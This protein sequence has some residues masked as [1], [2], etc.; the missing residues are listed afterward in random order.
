VAM[1]ADL[2][3]DTPRRLST[4]TLA[5]IAALLALALSPLLASLL[6][7]ALVDY[8]KSAIIGLAAFTGSWLSWLAR[9]AA[10]GPLRIAD[11]TRGI[12]NGVEA[13]INLLNTVFADGI[14]TGRGDQV[15][16]LVPPV[17]WLAAIGLAGILAHLIGGRAAG[18][19]LAAL[20]VAGFAYIVVFGF[21]R[22]AMLT[23]SSVIISTIAAVALGIWIGTKAVGRPRLATFVEGLMNVMQ[24]V[25]VFSYLVPTLLF[26]GYGPS[27]ALVATV[28]Y[29]LPPIV[30]ATM[31]GLR[32][33]PAEVIEFG[34]MAGAGQRAM[35]WKIKLPVALPQLA[36]GI[37][38]TIMAC[39]NIV[40]IASM[41]GAGGLGFLVL[42]ALRKL[43]IGGA[44]QAGIAIVVL[45]VILDRLSLAAARLAASGTRIRNSG[46]PYGRMA[47]IWFVAATAAAL[48]VPALQSW[49]KELTLTTAPFWNGL[50]SWININ[51]FEPLDAVRSFTLINLMNPTKEF[52]LSLPW[53]LVIALVMLGGLMAGGARL[54]LTV[55]AMAAFIALT[56]FW[57]PAIVSVYLVGLG[58]ILSLAIGLPIG[59]VVS[60]KQS[61]RDA[62]GLA[63]DTLQ[64]LP[65]LVYLLPAVM[66]FRNGDFS[67]LLA[68]VSYAV[69]PAVRYSMHAFAGVPADRLELA[70]MSG[71]SRWQT[72]KWVRLPAAFPTLLLGLNQT[73]MMAMAMLVITALVGT[74]DLGQQVFI[75]LSRAKV[76]DGII[77]GLCV[78]ALALIAD[79]IIKA[80]ARNAARNAGV[81]P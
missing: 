55:G 33:V 38:Q 26:L 69:A 71:A 74:R 5:A 73:I 62:A 9:E 79:S 76:G 64:T 53:V 72:F 48:M 29:A 44:L 39:L 56:G 47:L 50:V 1:T 45:A 63:L 25:P 67:A 78:A 21:W 75:A 54:A 30:H 40:V 65:T 37:N 11:I 52:L 80:W 42:T 23:L 2:S 49:P 6:P 3:I 43:D 36:I 68:I 34:R 81:D 41:I 70:A 12:A 15:R 35:F 28:I 8:P 51:W 14:P 46:T 24:T 16:T 61:W 7:P 19:R 17:S 20:T 57:D 59:Y 27:A 31:L 60:R 22:E 18:L 10:I 4:G 66:V 77:A 13:P 32:A 58:T